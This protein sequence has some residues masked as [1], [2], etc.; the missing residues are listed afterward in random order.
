MTG[1]LGMR[2]T[3]KNGKVKLPTVFL[4]G[5]VSDDVTNVCARG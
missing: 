2:Q 3:E 4:M 5:S 1:V